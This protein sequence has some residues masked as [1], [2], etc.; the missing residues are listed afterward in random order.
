[1]LLSNSATPVKFKSDQTSQYPNSEAQ[2]LQDTPK[3]FVAAGQGWFET[4][5]HI[6]LIHAKLS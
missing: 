3:A 2:I 6:F 5:F 1:M 4:I